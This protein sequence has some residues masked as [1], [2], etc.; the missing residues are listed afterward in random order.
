M[1]S[2]VGVLHVVGS[3]RLGGAERM[4]VELANRVHQAGYRAAVLSTR[5]GGP[6]E[7]EVRAD[8]P[9]LALDRARRWDPTCFQRFRQ[10]IR[11]HD[12]RLVQ[13]HGPGP[14]QYVTTALLPGGLE[15]HHI[16]HVHNAR[17]HAEDPPP[18]FR[19]RLAIR[20]GTQAVIGVSRGT[21]DWLKARVRCP[22]ERTFLLRNGVELQRFVDA[23]PADLRS[24]LGLT[25]ETVLVAMVAN[26]RWE[27]DHLTTL[28]AL[29]ACPSRE[30]VRL[31]LVGASPPSEEEYTQQVR[32][33]I[34][35]LALRGSVIHLGERRDIPEVLA[36][37]DAAV[38][39]SQRE[40]GPLALL[41]YMAA[42][43]PFAATRVGEIGQELPEG[44]GSIFVRPGDSHALSR[45]L[46]ALVAMGP[47]E[48]RHLGER[49]RALVQR[50]Y[51][52]GRTAERL[53]AIYEQVL[54]WPE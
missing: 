12:I 4:A 5:G 40:S 47:A 9:V 1:T 37:C 51:D 39:S 28:K 36:G 13:S 45:A 25:A 11:K 20:M 32:Q 22:A 29:A 30:R 8:V 19:T 48:R 43:L 21:C 15:C 17:S 23:R 42:G 26:L 34:A 7:D 41:E 33:T 50:E 44:E 2:G 10:F 35:A 49:G 46:E 38:L 54:R 27:K 53:T 3:L 24:E 16:H 52:Q 31:L 14:L 6:L 18:D